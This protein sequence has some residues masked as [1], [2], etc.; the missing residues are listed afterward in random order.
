MF[1][2]RLLGPGETFSSLPSYA[3]LA[4]FAT[5]VTWGYVSVAVAGLRL[6]AL[7]INGGVPVF[8]PYSPLV[9]SLTAWLSA[10][11]WCCLGLRFYRASARAQTARLGAPTGALP[12]KRLAG[13]PDRRDAAPRLRRPM[14]HPSGHKSR[15]ASSGFSR[16]FN[17]GCS[18]GAQADR[19][20]GHQAGREGMGAV[21]DGVR[22]REL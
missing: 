20:G 13:D 18:N 6:A 11:V 22:L 4:H 7:S 16:S 21:E 5:E 8:V 10:L 19:V 12:R 3:F 17:P 14:P 9:R 2:F 15:R 1:G